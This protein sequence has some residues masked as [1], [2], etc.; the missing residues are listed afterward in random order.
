M[1]KRGFILLACAI[2]VL[3]ILLTFNGLLASQEY[4]LS[5]LYKLALERSETIQIAREELY[6]SEQG[7]DKAFSAFLPTFS[8]FGSHIRYSGE[9]RSSISVL[10]PDYSNSW[11]VR[12]D[13][14][15][16]L[17]GQEVI[18]YGISKDSIQKSIYDLNKVKEDYLLSVAAAY[19]D[20]LKSKKSLDIA[21][22]NVE[23][24]TK[25]RD[26]A[27]TRLK[28]GEVTKTVLLRAEAELSGAQS[29]L[30]KAENNLKLAKII[31]ARIVGITENYDVKESQESTDLKNIVPADCQLSTID[32][33]KEKAVSERTELKAIAIEKKIAEDKI[34]YAKGSYW[35]TLSVEGVYSRKEDYPSSVSAVGETIYGGLKLDFPFFEGGLRMAEVREARAK[36]RQTEY[37]FS[38]LKNSI[39]IDVED[40]YLSVIT[41]SGILTKLETQVNYAM[42]NYN[43]V[44]KQFEY[45]LA[46]SIDV[47]DANTLLVTAERE[48]ANARYDYQLAILK[49]KRATGTL[50]KTAVSMQ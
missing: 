22:A 29:D 44:S 31:L 6:I 25:H 45:G 32:C 2:S 13:R 14:S 4:S 27:K 7:K 18:S 47:M 21:K 5:D 42:D 28:I 15:L 35:P 34:K 8:A 46:N 30:I 49:L 24:L 3:S 40:A 9:K 1:N 17:G 38:D 41:Q 20:V 36:Q 23:R 50:L 37:R 10:Q 33:L 19:Y 39:N 12:L 43:A 48:L 16:S 11:G 26:A